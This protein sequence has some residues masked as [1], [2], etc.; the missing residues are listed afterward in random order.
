MNSRVRPA[1]RGDAL[2]AMLPLLPSLFGRAGGCPST[3]A[4]NPSP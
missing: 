2:A 1:R 4:G 3:A